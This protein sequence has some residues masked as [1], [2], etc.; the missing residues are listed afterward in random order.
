[1]ATAVFLDTTIQIARL[2]GSPSF[3][4]AIK[5]QLSCVDLAVTSLVVK[6]EWK[7]RLLTDARYVLNTLRNNRLRFGDTL[8]HINRKISGNPHN[9]RKLSICLD[10]LATATDRSEKEVG[11][12]LENL[13]IMLLEDGAALFELNLHIIEDSGCGC[14][15]RDVVLSE[16]GRYDI[17]PRKCTTSPTLCGV[18]DFLKAKHREISII[19]DYLN[20]TTDDKSREITD[21]E[22]FIKEWK[23][24]A[25]NP[26]DK[27]PCLNYGDLAIALESS[28]IPIFYTTNEKE[29]KH[30]CSA[31]GQSLVVGIQ[32]EQRFDSCFPAILRQSPIRGDLEVT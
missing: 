18:T 9:R 5:Q 12:H 10:L 4:K 31:L 23:R 32:D 13:L 17:G 15:R 7:R 8:R 30:Y 3:K 6:Q 25:V 29:S 24:G 11:E 14:A 28:G 22:E 21:A 2:V 19:A 27:T 16:D 20:G 1:M 26:C